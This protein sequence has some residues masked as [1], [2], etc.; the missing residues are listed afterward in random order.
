MKQ[1]VQVAIRG[2][3]PYYTFKAEWRAEAKAYRQNIV[4]RK[5]RLVLTSSKEANRY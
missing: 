4:G 1:G 2:E 5:P 3:Y